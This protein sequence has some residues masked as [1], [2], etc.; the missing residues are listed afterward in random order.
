MSLQALSLFEIWSKAQPSPTH[1]T[2]QQKV[3]GGGVGCA[4]CIQRSAKENVKIAKFGQ[5]YQW[6]QVY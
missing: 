3:G 1:T 2:P 6:R 5:I 4:L